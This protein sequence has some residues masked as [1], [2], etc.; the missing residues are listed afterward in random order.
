MNDSADIVEHGE[1][2]EDKL[3]VNYLCPIC[4]LM[5]LPGFGLGAVVGKGHLTAAGGEW[6]LFVGCAAPCP[7]GDSIDFF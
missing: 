6:V 7:I 2:S 1:S 5:R 4:F 3:I